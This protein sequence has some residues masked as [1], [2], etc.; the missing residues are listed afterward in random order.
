MGTHLDM[1]NRRSNVRVDDHV[2]QKT[3]ERARQLVF[4]QGIS[5]SSI[6]LKK[7]L[8]S[9]SGVPTLVSSTFDEF[10]NRS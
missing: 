6:H 7:V 5:L 4:E 10:P 1:H 9:I 2:R 8:G 3:V